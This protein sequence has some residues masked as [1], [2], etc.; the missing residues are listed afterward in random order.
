MGLH[1]TNVE[2]AVLQLIS[3]KKSA[4]GYELNALIEERGYRQWA[5]IGKTSIYNGLKKLLKKT[6]I[7]E[8]GFEKIAGKGPAPKKYSITP[9]GAG[10]LRDTTLE[11][12]SGA[13]RRENAFELALASIPAIGFQ[14]ATAA[15]L[16][17]VKA[18]DISLKSLGKVYAEKGG[19]SLPLFVSALFE[20]PI[21]IIEADIEYTKKLTLRL[22]A[23]HNEKN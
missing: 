15:L 2:T 19:K 10:L 9:K 13:I 21:K 8:S 6:L 5:G 22:M 7:R 17:R 12:L 16:Q 14:K 20:R 4:S 11:A 1:M 3:E 23:E 18:L